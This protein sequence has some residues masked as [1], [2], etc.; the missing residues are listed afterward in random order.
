MA[1]DDLN[2]FTMQT[3]VG[4]LLMFCLL[5][6]SIGFMY[7][8]NPTGLGD[9]GDILDSA[10]TSSSN[11]LVETEGNADTLLNIT[12]NTNPEIS[13]LGSRDVVATSYGA[14]G[15]T[16][17]G[18]NTAKQLISWVFTGTTGKILLGVLGGIIGLLGYFYI[19][20]HIRTGV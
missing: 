7:Y 10:K 15:S 17:S 2:S 18:F 11:F 20:K 14:F 4:G 5:S 8:N 13:T 19:S 3:V 6:F 9:T 1:T 12:S 16:K